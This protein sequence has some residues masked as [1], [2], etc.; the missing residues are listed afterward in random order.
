MDRRLAEGQPSC[1]AIRIRKSGRKR[2]KRTHRARARP[3]LTAGEFCCVMR[4]RLIEL[5]Y[6]YES[7]KTLSTSLPLSRQL[8][9]S[10]FARQFSAAAGTNRTWRRETTWRRQV[11]AL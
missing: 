11:G 6:V 1:E 9:V 10:L 3:G 8:L 2:Q 5:N 4:A 7:F